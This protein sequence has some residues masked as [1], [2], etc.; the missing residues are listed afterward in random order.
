MFPP[1]VGIAK[2][3]HVVTFMTKR[4]D[5]SLA[6]QKEH[7]EGTHVG[8]LLSQTSAQPL[9]F[10]RFYLPREDNIRPFSLGSPPV[11]FDAISHLTF[12]SPEAFESTWQSKLTFGEHLVKDEERFLERSATVA[13]A[14][15]ERVTSEL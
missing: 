12:E 10:K 11:S 7:L 14:A 4:S 5:L 1:L 2:P 3:F 13:F 6:A 8:L 15:D 9:N